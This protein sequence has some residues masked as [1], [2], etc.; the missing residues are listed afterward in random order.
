[1][2]RRDS[3][4]GAARA[5][6]GGGA[7]GRGRGELAGLSRRRAVPL[8]VAVAWEWR[9]GA[10]RSGAGTPSWACPDEASRGSSGDPEVRRRLFAWNLALRW[11]AGAA[12]DS[13][14]TWAP[15]AGEFEL[16]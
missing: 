13:R 14:A 7:K 16:L 15:N 4:A 5:K 3:D 12:R 10:T 11:R 9:G 2:A 8:R 6:G 1:M